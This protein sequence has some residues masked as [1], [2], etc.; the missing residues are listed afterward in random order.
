[1]DSGISVSGS[2][3]FFSSCRSSTGTSSFLRFSDPPPPYS[4]LSGNAK[5]YTLGALVLQE[6][7][8]SR[9]CFIFF[10]LQQFSSRRYYYLFYRPY[11]P[12]FSGCIAASDFP[13]W[14]FPPPS[15]ISEIAAAAVVASMCAAASS[16]STYL[17]HSAPLSLR[18]RQERCR[19]RRRRRR[20]RRLF[21]RRR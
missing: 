20:R 17:A 6:A 8:Y 18:F 10:H 5:R 2:G 14:F 3:P 9:H 19:R 16:F 7:A 13:S 1:M 12:F 15:S 4:P 11:F 21:Q